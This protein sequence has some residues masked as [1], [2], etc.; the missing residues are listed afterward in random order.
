MPWQGGSLPNSEVWWRSQ[1]ALCARFRVALA[2][3]R[4]LCPQLAP[5]AGAGP[6]FCPP[7][8]PSRAQHKPSLGLTAR[9]SLCQA[10]VHPDSLWHGCG[11]SP[12]WFSRT[13]LGANLLC[14][15]VFG[16]EGE[17][18]PGQGKAGMPTPLGRD[19]DGCCCP[20]QLGAALLLAPG[21]LCNTQKQQFGGI[22]PPLCPSH[23]SDHP[24]EKARTPWC[25]HQG[26]GAEHPFAFPKQV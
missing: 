6:A 4:L 8:P 24:L 17:Q 21:R 5:G 3:C 9:H 19:G 15:F 20:Q 12:G 23:P 26:G 1:W 7:S 18:H 14:S 16:W 25:R 10:L 13:L 2:G 11:K 22:L